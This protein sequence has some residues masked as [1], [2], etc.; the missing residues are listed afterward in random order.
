MEMYEEKSINVC[1][2]IKSVKFL[3]RL[4]LSIHYPGVWYL[5]QLR[6][7]PGIGWKARRN[8]FF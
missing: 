6:W 4:T 8:N 3:E 2:P 5:P 1:W 7:M